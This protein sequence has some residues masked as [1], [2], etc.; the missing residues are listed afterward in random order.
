MIYF[1][2]ARAVGLVKIGHARNPQTRFV[3]IQTHSPV[4]LSLE[5]VTEGG[6]NEERALHEAFVFALS[7]KKSR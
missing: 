6:L 7:A 3:S 2:T 1:I 5:R 4:S